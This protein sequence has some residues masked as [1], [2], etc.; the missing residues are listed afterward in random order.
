MEEI[1]GMKDKGEIFERLLHAAARNKVKVQMFPGLKGAYGRIRERR[2][3]IA[4]NQRID[5][6]N[7]TLA[8]E[9]AHFYLHSDKY[10]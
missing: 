2:I 7:Y 10:P 9:L 3:G 1:R 4:S 6:I 8:H 5:E